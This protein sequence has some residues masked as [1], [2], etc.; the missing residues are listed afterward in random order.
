MATMRFGKRARRVGLVVGL[1]G[2]VA[3]VNAPSSSAVHDD[4]VFELD[5]NVKDDAGTGEDWQNVCPVGTP[6]GAP[7]LTCLGNTTAVATSFD[8]DGV[9][10]S[11]FTTGGSKD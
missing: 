11:I 6:A 1:I 7:G 3:V 4:G 10:A 5:R 8:V 9:N 2:V